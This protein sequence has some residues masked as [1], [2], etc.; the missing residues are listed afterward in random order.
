MGN[1]AAI[2][3]LLLI[4][5]VIVC[6]SFFNYVVLGQLKKAKES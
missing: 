1:S 3:Y 2:A 4:V 5:T 6:S